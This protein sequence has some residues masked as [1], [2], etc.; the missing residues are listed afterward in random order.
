MKK[1]RD[2]G[3]RT[4]CVRAGL[5]V[6]A[7]AAFLIADTAR[8]SMSQLPFGTLVQSAK[9]IVVGDVLDMK[10]ELVDGGGRIETLVTL[11][12]YD[13]FKGDYLGLLTVRIG[14]GEV[15]GVRMWEEDQPEFAVGKAV[16]LFVEPQG[17]SYTVTG[18]FQGKFDLLGD[19]VYRD[20]EYQGT[21][22]E[23]RQRVAKALGGK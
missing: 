18:W 19:G 15:G 11:K 7:I 22:D 14:G 2:P 20:G 9:L 6:L 13:S 5:G 3:H 12:V 4:A 16:V 17:S 10:S 21:V 23:F 8:A 1:L